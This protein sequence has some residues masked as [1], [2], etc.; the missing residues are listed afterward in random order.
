VGGSTWLATPAYLI[1]LAIVAVWLV[2]LGWG[3]RRLELTAGE[4]VRGD[5]A[6]RTA[7]AGVRGK[8]R[9]A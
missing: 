7:A 8:V 1:L 6:D 5:A 2:S 9:T 3:L 4:P